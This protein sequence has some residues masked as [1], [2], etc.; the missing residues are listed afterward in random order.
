[1]GLIC[2][3]LS[4]CF[5][6]PCGKCLLYQA[7]QKWVPAILTCLPGS[8]VFICIFCVYFAPRG[9]WCSQSLPVASLLGQQASLALR[10]ACLKAPCAYHE[11]MKTRNEEAVTWSCLR[12]GIFFF[13]SVPSRP[14][15]LLA[16]AGSNPLESNPI[17]SIAFRPGRPSR[18][19]SE[20][21]TLPSTAPP[22]HPRS[23]PTDGCRLQK[24]V[25]AST[26]PAAAGARAPPR[27]PPLPGVETA[28]TP[29]LVLVSA[30]RCRL[31]R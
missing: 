8:A 20:R 12:L 31:R 10:C 2:I 18:D 16:L 26:L 28:S 13:S 7:A 6:L 9:V 15:P 11:T 21:G 5:A 23:S 19:G 17:Q 24:R 1:M 29:A 30:C 22:L 3:A 4:S 25:T 27:R 14:L